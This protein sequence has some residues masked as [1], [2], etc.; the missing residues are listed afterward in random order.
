MTYPDKSVPYV[1][2]N[3]KTESSARTVILPTP[4]IEALRQHVRSNGYV[5]SAGRNPEAPLPYASFKR[6]YRETF[7]E[8]GIWHRY[9]S[10]DFRASYAT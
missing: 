4:V 8:L 3:P 1:D 2:S 7:Q 6:L 9:T 10:H 5:L